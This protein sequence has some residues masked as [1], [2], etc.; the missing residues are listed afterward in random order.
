MEQRSM[1]A[2]VSTFARAYH[3][4]HKKVK[5]FD[6]TLAGSLLTEQEY[7]Q[8]AKNMTDGISFFNPDFDGTTE[9]ALRWIV[10]RQLSPAPLGRAA[11]TERT[12]ETAVRLGARQYLILG[13][14]Y[15]SFAY[16]QPDWARTLQ[17]FELDHP[18]SAA[19]K[20]RRLMAAGLTVE[21]NV[22]HI[23]ADFTRA[24]WQA[25]L[26]RSEAFHSGR[27]SFCSMLGLSYYLSEQTFEQLL[28]TLARL[29]CKGSAL[30]F[31]YPDEQSDTP[32]AGARTQKQRMLAEA[33]H[34]TMLASYSCKD[35]EM[36]LAAHGFL[37][38]EHLYPQELTQQYFAHYNRHNPDSPMRALDNVNLCLAVKQ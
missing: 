3:A 2:L 22:H 28:D 10:D 21:N 4:R 15:D 30:V 13:A 11:F 29:L 8:I 1:T 32:K 19:D 20:R 33:A 26:I 24:Q 23:A 14:G 31:D 5:I 38:Y 27:V 36:R 37:L 9:E 16:R 25:P 7:G 18:I 17:I 35:M 12:L 6:D 34:E